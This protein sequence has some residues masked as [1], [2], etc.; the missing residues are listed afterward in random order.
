MK[1]KKVI[2]MPSIKQFRDTIHH[3]TKAARFDGL[4]ENDEPIYNMDL[5]PT[6]NAIGTVKIHGTNA[7]ICY[8]S[9]DGLWV[10]SKKNIIT[11]EK[12]NA[13]FAFF[14]ESKKILFS[15][16]CQF[17]LTNNGL[18]HSKNTVTIYGEWAG[19]GIQSGVGIS[20]L[21]KHFY[22]FG[23][24][25]T[26]HDEDLDSYWVDSFIFDFVD[27]KNIYHI[28]DFKTFDI[29]I[30]FNNPLLSNNMM[31]LMVESVESECPVASKLGGVGIGEGIVFKI[32]Y[33]GKIYR[34]KMKGEKHAGKSK[35]KSAKKVDDKKLQLIID[36]VEKVTPEWR[37][38]QMYQETFDTLNGGIASI[39]GTG[40][41][42]GMVIR[43]I[44]KEEIET[45]S[46]VGLIPKDINSTVSKKA[47]IWFMKKLDEESGLK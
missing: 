29:K 25:V 44:L 40:D 16:L 41:Y 39:K 30:D 24:K 13:G 21:E 42:I 15:E 33:K 35:V 47:R 34:F 18:N 12:D 6:L 10:Q 37:L 46:D 36:T 22:I 27:E 43:D 8:N 2:R 4:D 32:S 7:S 14:V 3:I 45:L 11:S 1:T 38:K 31:V 19:K 20:K 23:I 9:I 17:V 5:L 26:P 28:K